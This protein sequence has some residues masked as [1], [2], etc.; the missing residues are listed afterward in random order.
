MID[1]QPQPQAQSH[2]RA[3]ETSQEVHDLETP[4]NENINYDKPKNYAVDNY[5]QELNPRK[6]ATS[7]LDIPY[8]TDIH[9]NQ[10]KTIRTFFDLSNCDTNIG[11]YKN[12]KRMYYEFI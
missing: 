6:S 1:P 3:R 2:P 9:I 10:V 7:N 8:D 5:A 4:S 11:T 12:M